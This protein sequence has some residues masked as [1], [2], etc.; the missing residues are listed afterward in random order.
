MIVLFTPTPP[1]MSSPQAEEEKEAKTVVTPEQPTTT[2]EVD[3]VEKRKR[4]LENLGNNKLW[5]D[6]F[7]L[8]LLLRSIWRCVHSPV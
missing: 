1:S 2:T 6:G 5:Y 8:L 7:E 4:Q 3:A